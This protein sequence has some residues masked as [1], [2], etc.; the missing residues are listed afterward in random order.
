MAMN[1]KFAAALG[2]ATAALA[3]GAQADTLSVVKER[4]ELICGT[5]SSLPGFA[6]LQ[7]DGTWKGFQIDLCR[8]IAAAVLGDP[9]KASMR[10]VSAKERF[11]ALQSG[12]VD[13]LT[14]NATWTM[15]RDTALGARFVGVSFYDGQGFLVPDELGVEK[16]EDMAG[17]TACVGGGTTNERNINDA[18]VANGIDLKIVTY[19]GL[20][21][22]VPA[23]DQGR[24]DALTTDISG[25]VSFRTKLTK[26]ENY[27][28]APFAISKEPLGPVVRQGDSAWESVVRWVMFSTIN[29]E[30]L[31]LTRD[32]IASSMDSDK[33]AVRRF[34][35]ADGTLCTDIGLAPDCFAKVIGAVGNYGEIYD[36]HLG[37]DTKINLPRG[38]NRLWSKGGLLYAPPM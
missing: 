30:E 12:E 10:P 20:E 22:A 1:W 34:V 19:Q 11:T 28:I 32:N 38:M 37:P 9:N 8:G 21:N 7:Q 29:A 13:V 26:P 16:P 2:I 33:P 15:N 14:W 18:L 31:G 23:F 5:N 25:L 4:G 17:L 24:C 27:A 35:G 36:R 6:D 3:T